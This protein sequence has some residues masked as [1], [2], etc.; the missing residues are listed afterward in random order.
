MLRA[1]AL[2]LKWPVQVSVFVTHFLHHALA[3]FVW[4]SLILHVA[5]PMAAA[6]MNVHQ[7]TQE[8]RKFLSEGRVSWRSVIAIALIP[9]VLVAARQAYLSWEGVRD[10]L[11]ARGYAPDHGIHVFKW[12]IRTGRFV[13]TLLHQMAA[14]CGW[15]WILL[16][17]V[18][19][20][21]EAS[22][23]AM[24]LREA[25]LD[26]FKDVGGID[27]RYLL[28]VSAVPAL[29]MALWNARRAY[30]R[31]LAMAQDHLPK[32]AVPARPA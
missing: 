27:W 18:G 11:H 17:L 3:F 31:L 7:I 9:A 16:A 4:A 26:Y 14:F 15:V 1:Q 13:A 2:R 23:H 32:L 20:L 8:G 19:S 30:R 22:N 25:G 12:P 5:I 29:L 10:R 6:G 28:A 24:S 21:G